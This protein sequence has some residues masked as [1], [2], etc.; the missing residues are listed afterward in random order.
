MVPFISEE[1]PSDIQE[2]REVFQ[3]TQSVTVGHVYDRVGH[4]TFM[5][6]VPHGTDHILGVSFVTLGA[7]MNELACRRRIVSVSHR[8]VYTVVSRD[9]F[10]VKGV[11]RELIGMTDASGL[12]AFIDTTGVDE[13]SYGFFV[14]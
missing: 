12:S 4:V 5:R 10:E 8:N 7:S 14:H 9:H 11:E 6:V 2:E 13:S 3:Y 1:Q